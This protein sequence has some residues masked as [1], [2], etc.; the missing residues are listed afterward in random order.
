MMFWDKQRIDDLA[1]SEW[2]ARQARGEVISLASLAETL[3]AT[4]CAGDAGV[5]NS[6][7]RRTIAIR[8][9]L[10]RDRETLLATARGG[11]HRH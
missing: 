4:V 8:E 9:L 5:S 10:E 6:R 11:R 7:R 3:T 2:D 1:R